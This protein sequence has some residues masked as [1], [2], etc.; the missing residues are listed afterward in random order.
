MS[1]GLIAA[2]SKDDQGCGARL[3]ADP[4]HPVELCEL[5]DGAQERASDFAAV[6]MHFAA[7]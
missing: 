1:G 3:V 7:R 5:A 4:E 6:S 2:Q